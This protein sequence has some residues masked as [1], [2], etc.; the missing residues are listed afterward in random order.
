MTADKSIEKMSFEEALEKL[1][2]IVNKMD[3]GE[4]SLEQA[5]KDYE[6]GVKLKDH[7]E[8]KLQ[9][10]KL[11]I[12]QITKKTDGSLEQSEVSEEDLG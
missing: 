2:T 5:I 7:C 10:A 3:T 6:L 12:S 11:K 1:N 9:E 8:K 4:E